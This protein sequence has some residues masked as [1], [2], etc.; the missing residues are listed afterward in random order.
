M[1]VELMYDGCAERCIINVMYNVHVSC[2]CDTVHCT[3]TLYSSAE[4]WCRVSTARRPTGSRAYLTIRYIMF[5]RSMVRLAV[6]LWL[7]HCYLSYC[8][9]PYHY[10]YGALCKLSDVVSSRLVRSAS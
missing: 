6:A 1:T 2:V 8:S 3:Y 4:S 7:L 9:P 5:N 10:Y